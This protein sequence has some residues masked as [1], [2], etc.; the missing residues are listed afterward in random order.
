MSP[1]RF[2]LDPTK[3]DQLLH[4][5][6]GW[7]GADEY[8]PLELR[9]VMIES[10]ALDR[11]GDVV[12]GLAPEARAV[13]V[14][15]DDTPMRRSGRDLK[16]A[17][18]EVLVAA[19]FEVEVCELQAGADGAVHADFDRLDEVAAHLRPGVP[20]VA[21]GSGTITDLTKHACFTYEQ[22]SGEHLPLVFCPTAISVLAFSARMAVIAKDGSS[23][24]GHHG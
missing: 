10:G 11:L 2:A 6:R 13:L 3:L 12:S 24:P 7:P 19:D 8:P 9:R 1:A 4:T 17:V 20:V 18:A 14:I 15:Q 5:V 22:R 21:L 16:R 23:G